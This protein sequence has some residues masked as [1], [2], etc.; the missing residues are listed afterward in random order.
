LIL[1]KIFLLPL[2]LLLLLALLLLPV[3]A[4]VPLD[5]ASE[6]GSGMGPWTRAP[7]PWTL[8]LA[9]KPTYIYIYIYMRIWKACG[10]LENVSLAWKKLARPIWL[11]VCQRVTHCFP[12]S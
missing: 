10:S 11:A 2:H 5:E 3:G 8:A 6:L 7:V 1:V 12:F 4:A 9:L